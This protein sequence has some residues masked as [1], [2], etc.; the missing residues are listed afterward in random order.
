MT[1][2]MKNIAFFVLIALL[3]FA[4]YAQQPIEGSGENFK[5]DPL[6]QAAINTVEDGQITQEEAAAPPLTAQIRSCI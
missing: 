4:G 3:G 6:G 1:V 5:T 2:N